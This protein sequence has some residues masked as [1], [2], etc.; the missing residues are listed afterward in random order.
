MNVPELLLL[1]G[2]HLRRRELLTSIQVCKSWHSVLS[3]L[4]YQKLDRN[5]R[6][7]IPA[8]E[9]Y[10]HHIRDLTLTIGDKADPLV[11][12]YTG[13]RSIRCNSL[14]RLSLLFLGPAIDKMDEQQQKTQLFDGGTGQEWWRAAALV[15]M[16]QNLQILELSGHQSRINI[17][18]WG[19]L[20]AHCPPVLQELILQDISLTREDLD[21]IFELAPQLIKLVILQC[22]TEFA[23]SPCSSECLLSAPP[24]PIPPPQFP[25]LKH[26]SIDTEYPQ[27]QGLEW[28]QACPQLESLEWKEPALGDLE[29]EMGTVVFCDILRTQ[30][31][32]Q[33][34]SLTISGSTCL[35]DGQYGLILDA[36]AHLTKIAV[37]DSLVWYSFMH[38]L[39]RHFPTLEHLDISEC[40]DMRSWMCQRILTNCPRLT[41]F[42]TTN[43]NMNELVVG[44]GAEESR[45]RQ[46]S[47]DRQWDENHALDEVEELSPEVK[48]YYWSTRNRDVI[49]VRP[50]SCL[51]LKHL[52]VA[53][54]RLE[55]GWDE[56][57]FAQL[58][59]LTQLIDLH[60][61]YDQ[62]L[63]DSYVR[64]R[65][66]DLRLRSGL[67]QLAAL[68]QLETFSFARTSQQMGE[69]DV[70]WIKRQWPGIQ[71][72]TNL[73]SDPLLNKELNK[74]LD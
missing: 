48:G 2:H 43:M 6:P 20:F 7:T 18:S 49:R 67:G 69:E 68:K 35:S 28:I 50:W 59:K 65:A 29:D 73:H 11:K 24:Q 40:H 21:Q 74:L 57:V 62:A 19:T 12:A 61:G 41:F 60:V 1:L 16:N 31:W 33:L 72:T 45:A 37:P 14:K 8:L 39:E 55:D 15:M 5:D 25:L 23:V 58:A 53:M 4:L 10:A 36:C 9:R 46:T 63:P 17:F 70:L 32:S 42:K 64:G 34:H 47:E 13:R 3:T 44:L 51:G 26:L 52:Y 30:L 54:D 38:S 71:I 66:L 27:L 56:Q 22:E